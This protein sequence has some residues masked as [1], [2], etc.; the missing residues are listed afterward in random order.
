M[1]CGVNTKA[2]W[3]SQLLR[4]HGIQLVGWKYL[5]FQDYPADKVTNMGHARRKDDLI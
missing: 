5:L 3:Q 4:L 1:D 2:L